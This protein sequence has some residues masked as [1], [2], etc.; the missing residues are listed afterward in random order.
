MYV[1]SILPEEI[2][3][4]SRASFPGKIE[5]IDKEDS[6]YRDAVEYLSSKKVLG[7][8]TE[9]RPTFSPSQPQYGISLLQL[10]SGD[11][12]FLFRVKQMGLPKE[13][14]DILADEK[15]LKIGAAV[16]DDIKGL[17]KRGGFT[18]GGFVDLQK[19]VWEWGIKDKSVKKMA[20]IIMG[21]KVS[22][23]QQLSNWEAGTLSDSQKMYAATDSWICEMMYSEL[24][25]APK[26]PLSE[27]EINPAPKR[28]EEKVSHGNG[29]PLM[30]MIL[31][32]GAD[33]K[34]KKS[35]KKPYWLKFKSKS[36]SGVTPK[37]GGAPRKKKNNH[38]KKTPKATEP[39]G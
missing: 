26:N 22:K 33:K 14:C 25:A 31:A 38:K 6:A 15:I 11:R 13:L 24:L 17:Q 34:K 29:V 5:V 28:E 30:E 21:V 3:K 37:D 19:M 8:D 39:Q 32:E 4:L 9:S 1:K 7:F 2:E 27:E 18:P 10:S 20:A 36:A 35:G 23:T 16:S 12:A